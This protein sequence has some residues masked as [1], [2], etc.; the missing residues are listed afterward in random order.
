MMAASKV[1]PQVLVN[2]CTDKCIIAFAN[3]KEVNEN[4]RDRLLSSEV[5][6]E[7]SL[8]DLKSKLMKKDNEINSLK[9]EHSITKDQLQTMIE[10]Y[11]ACKKELESTQITCENGWNLM[12]FC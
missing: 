12:R 2:L 6:F 3:I 8:K 10:K 4:L 7:K 5:Q 1:S 11:H 9:H